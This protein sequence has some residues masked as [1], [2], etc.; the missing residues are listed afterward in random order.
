MTP[1]AKYKQA[2]R[3]LVGQLEHA[4]TCI[5]YCRKNHE[6]LQHGSGVPVE[7]LYR[8]TIEKAKVLI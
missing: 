6:D 2:I 3:E 8:V 1:T 5:E 7:L 4:I